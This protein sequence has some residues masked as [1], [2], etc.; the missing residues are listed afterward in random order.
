MGF[1][2]C[3]VSKALDYFCRKFLSGEE[4]WPTTNL[5]RKFFHNKLMHLTKNEHKLKEMMKILDA[6]SV[7]VQERHY[8]LKDPEDDIILA[9]ALVSEVLGKTVEWPSDEH[10]KARSAAKPEFGALLDSLTTGANDTDAMIIDDD[11]VGEGSDDDEDEAETMEWWHAAEAFGIPK[12]NELE[13]IPLMDTAEPHAEAIQDSR[14]DSEP[15]AKKQKV[16]TD[17]GPLPTEKDT[18]RACSKPTST[19]SGEEVR[20][21]FDAGRYQ[22]YMN[23]V[24]VFLKAAGSTVKPG[25]DVFQTSQLHVRMVLDEQKYA[26]EKRATFEASI[27]DAAEIPPISKVFSEHIVEEGKK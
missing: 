10:I 5:V 11:L 21:F 25:R 8:I 17:A 1:L 16:E 15:P 6:H 19:H 18:V 9:K 26:L 2:A 23:S 14:A 20:P 24:S 12:P 4:V 7:K 27:R 3:Y 13:P 22:A